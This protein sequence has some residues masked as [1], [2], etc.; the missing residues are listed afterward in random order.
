M[1]TKQEYLDIYD[2]AGVAMEVY[3]TLGKRGFEQN[4]ISLTKTVTVSYYCQKTTT[5]NTFCL[6]HRINAYYV[7]F[8]L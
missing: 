7:N 6:T 3:N 2:V 5:S 1:I 8:F 4:A